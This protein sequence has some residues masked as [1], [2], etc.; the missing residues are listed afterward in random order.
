MHAFIHS[1]IHSSLHPE[2]CGSWKRGIIPKAWFQLT[3]PTMKSGP[4][5]LPC[6]QHKGRAQSGHGQQRS[7]EAADS[8]NV[9]WGESSLHGAAEMN[10]TSIHKDARSIFGLAQWVEDPALP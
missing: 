5:C 7:E 6:R 4:G 9:T 2:A 3:K 10:L 8:S 1:S